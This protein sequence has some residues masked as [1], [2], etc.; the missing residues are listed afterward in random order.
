LIFI[1][2][3]VIYMMCMPNDVVSVVVVVR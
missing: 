3:L 2:P 1:S